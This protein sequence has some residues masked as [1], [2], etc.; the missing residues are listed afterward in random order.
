MEK[1]MSEDRFIEIINDVNI[2]KNNFIFIDSW[3]CNGITI[4]TINNSDKIIVFD[5]SIFKIFKSEFPLEYVNI[6]DFFKKMVEKH[7]NLYDYKI[8]FRVLVTGIK[9]AENSVL[10]II[11]KIKNKWKRNQ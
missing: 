8:V 10:S 2:V 11:N 7:L 1:K 4:L 9:N 6:I 5:E 3:E